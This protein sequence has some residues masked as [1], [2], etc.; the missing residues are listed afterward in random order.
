MH[1]GEYGIVRPS[2]PTTDRFP[3]GAVSIHPVPRASPDES[4]STAPVRGIR[5]SWV[6]G[7]VR[8]GSG[9]RYGRNRWVVSAGRT[10]VN[11]RVSEPPDSADQVPLGVVRDIVRL[12]HGQRR[13]DLDV[14]LGPQGLTQPPDLQ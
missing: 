3:Q 14:R 9:V 8:G 13:V 2:S 10:D 5:I 7:Q 4:R 12:G 6:L 11:G 1:N